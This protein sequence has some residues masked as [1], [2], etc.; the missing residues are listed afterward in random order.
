MEP[1]QVYKHW[2]CQEAS[3]L[4][5]ASVLCLRTL[6]KIS[7]SCL[8]AAGLHAAGR[9]GKQCSAFVE[10]LIWTMVVERSPVYNPKLVCKFTLQPLT[11]IWF[12][13]QPQTLKTD[14]NHP[15]LLSS[16][17][18]PGF[19]LLHQ[20]FFIIPY[21]S[22][23]TLDNISYL[24]ASCMRILFVFLCSCVFFPGTS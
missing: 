2:S 13:S 10:I 7:I 18:W 17:F 23:C 20:R 9:R 21:H 8:P 15:F 6:V 22:T 11:F 16:R 3:F 14:R 4:F 19:F 12:N 1:E 5:R 24:H